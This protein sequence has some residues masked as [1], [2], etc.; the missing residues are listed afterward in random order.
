MQRRPLGAESKLFTL[1]DAGAA[2]PSEQQAL[3]SDSVAHAK[4][5]VA[6]NVGDGSSWYQLAMALMAH[7]FAHGRT[8]AADLAAANKAFAHAARNGAARDADM[9]FNRGVLLRFLDDIQGALDCFRDA[10]ALDS[11][12]PWQL[13]VDELCSQATRVHD[14]VSTRGRLK[15]KRVV[16]VCNSLRAMQPPAGHASIAV[17]ALSPDVNDGGA[18]LCTIVALA[19]TP[20]AVP[21]VVAA[22]DS[23]GEGFALSAFGVQDASLREGTTVAV[24]SPSPVHVRATLPDGRQLAYTV[25]RVEGVA[26]LR[27][28]HNGD[29][30]IPQAQR[31]TPSVRFQV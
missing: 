26:M 6:L 15:P 12:L 18:T 24:L 30:K 23:S 5:A 13:R 3:V 27:C 1:V 8:R 10:G 4:A 22:V 21:L 29:W 17:H 7:A 19:S 11:E 31:Q 16:E 2:T 20:G 28:W 14:L 9:C 25:V